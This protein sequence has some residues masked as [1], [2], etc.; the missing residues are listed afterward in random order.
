M[1]QFDHLSGVQPVNNKICVHDQRKSYLK[2]WLKSGK[3]A[4]S[5][6]PQSNLDFKASN[7][8]ILA[9]HIQCMR[10]IACSFLAWRWPTQLHIK[11][12]IDHQKFS[13]DVFHLFLA[14]NSCSVGM[15]NQ[16]L[17]Q[18]LVGYGSR[19]ANLDQKDLLNLNELT[20]SEIYKVYTQIPVGLLTRRPNFKS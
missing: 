11:K 3:I 9:L 12:F 19:G 4:N 18:R 8:S 20:G 6:T 7:P 13:V 2:I 16:D 5:L 1:P 10:Y 17:I 14:K 15:S